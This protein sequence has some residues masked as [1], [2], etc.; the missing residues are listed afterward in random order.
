METT[1]RQLVAARSS[2]SKIGQK[3]L[4]IKLSFK[5][6]TILKKIQ[7]ELEAF[8]EERQKLVQK[9][10]LNQNPNEPRDPNLLTEEEQKQE[11]EKLQ[12]FQ[13]EINQVLDEKA[14]VMIDSIKISEF[15]DDFKISPEDLFLLGDVV[16]E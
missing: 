1:V 14:N 11:Q 16:S 10:N 5:V 8:D 7:Q 2:L 15:G 6:T 12:Q 4:P 13:S 9:F 3:E